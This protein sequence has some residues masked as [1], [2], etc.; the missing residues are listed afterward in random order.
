MISDQIKNKIENLFEEK[1]YEELIYFAHK[2]I[3]DQDRPPGLDV[4]IGSCYFLKKK[5]TKDDLINSL[6]FY[7]EAFLK[8]KNSIHGLSGITNYIHVSLIGARKSKDF[9]PYV[10]KAEKY[11][12]E[13][14]KFFNKNPDFL[15]LAKKLFWFQLDNQKLDYISQKMIDNPNVP[16]SDKSGAIFFYN[17]VYNWPQKKYS[18]QAKIN[19]KNFLKLKV[20]NLNEINFKENKRINLGFVSGDFTDQ[21]S[22]FYFVRDTLKFLDKNLFKVFLFS[23]NRGINSSLGQNQIKTVADEF[24]DLDKYSNQDCVNLIQSNK[25]NILIDLMGYTF[26]KRLEIFNSR[27]AP[28]Q[29]SWLATCNTVGFNTIDY[30]IADNNLITSD[31]EHLYP[32]KILKLPDIWNVHCGNGIERNFTKSPCETNDYFTFGSLNNFHKI[33]DEVVEAWSRIL[34][35]CD[36]SKLILKS[37]SFETNNEKIFEKFKKH[38]LESKIEILD[39]RDFINKNDH[40]NVYKRIDLGLDTFPYNGVTTTFESLWMGVPV[41]V[42]KGFNF[43]SRCGFSIINN[44]N[45]K[46]LITNNIDEYVDRAI[47]FYDNREEFIKLKSELFKNILSTP[48]FNTQRFSKNFAQALLGLIE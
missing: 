9:L 26:S 45:F 6:K 42:L 2:F 15:R 24:I 30:L 41:L 29:I 8:G 13:S 19:S 43:N 25:I 11:F 21:H 38:D 31:E 3:S 7:E 22:I 12:N 44:S 1:K 17:Y 32:E 5:K 39:I 35:K 46:N 33:S 34:K 18:D 47:Y 10:Q 4:L 36:K 37:S 23:F 14:E 28:V 48:L 40:L 16:V 27:V 20:K